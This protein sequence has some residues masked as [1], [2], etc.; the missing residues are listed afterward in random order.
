MTTSDIPA[1]LVLGSTFFA[2]F[3]TTT[4]LLV[5]YVVEK[6]GIPIYVGIPPLCYLPY[7]DIEDFMMLDYD[8]ADA[9][10]VGTVDMDVDEDDDFEV[11]EPFATPVRYFTTPRNPIR[12]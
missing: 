4:Y 9:E 1:L 7:D 11:V 8:D 5:M 2:M 12:S 3:F 6:S 10:S